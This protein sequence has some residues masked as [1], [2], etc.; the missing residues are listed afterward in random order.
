MKLDVDRDVKLR[1]TF[2]TAEGTL[3]IANLKCWVAAAPLQDGL[4]DL[5]VSRDVMAKLGYCPRSL[6]LSARRAQS[7]Y[8]LDQ[9]GGKDTPLMAAM[10]VVEAMEKIP[11]SPEEASLYP[12][13]EQACFPQVTPDW[14]KEN[15]QAVVRAKLKDKAYEVRLEDECRRKNIQFREHVTSYVACFS[16]KQLLRTMMSI[17]KI[18]GEPEDMSEQI[19][20]DKL[21]DIAKK[22]M[23]DVDPDLESLFDDIELRP[24]VQ[25]TT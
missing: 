10:K 5:I 13:E 3:V 9:L 11:S 17:W 4:G 15:D 23:N 20:K 21:Q 22:P 1:L 16:D 14:S 25:R 6:L 8:D 7:V 18:R 19:L 24:C 12:E 2:E